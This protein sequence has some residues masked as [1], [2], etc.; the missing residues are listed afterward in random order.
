M[1]CEAR[2]SEERWVEGKVRSRH[3]MEGQRV[4]Q[5]K[6]LSLFGTW[7]GRC[8]ARCFATTSIAAFAA[9]ATLVAATLAAATLAAATLAAATLAAAR[10]DHLVALAHILQGCAAH[11]LALAQGLSIAMTTRQARRTGAIGTIPAIGSAATCSS[12]ATYPAGRSLIGRGRG[13]PA[14]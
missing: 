9:A 12:A 1:W 13:R 14:S 5:V 4:Q 2:R 7:I 10:I 8:S 11:Q 3:L 6:Y